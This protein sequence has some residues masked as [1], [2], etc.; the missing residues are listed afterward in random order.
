MK[1]I[2]GPKSCDTLPL[3]GHEKNVFFLAQN[4]N[5][6]ISYKNEYFNVHKLLIRTRNYKTVIISTV[7]C[8]TYLLLYRYSKTPVFATLQ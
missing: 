4:A 1:K 2:G 5:R 7:T 8:T 3:S 6:Q